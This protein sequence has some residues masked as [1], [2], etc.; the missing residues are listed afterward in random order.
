MI[1]SCG[2]DCAVEEESKVKYCETDEHKI[3]AMKWYQ[4]V[5]V[6]IP[7]KIDNP[8]PTLEEKKAYTAALVQC[9]KQDDGLT[10]AELQFIRG[11]QLCFG[12]GGE[13]I[14]A[15]P[16]LVKMSQEEVFQK[17]K[18][19]PNLKM[20]RRALIYHALEASASDGITQPEL[21]EIR[22]IAELLEME[23]QIV[24]QLY[25]TL[26]AELE[27]R[28]RKMKAIWGPEGNPWGTKYA[29]IKKLENG[30]L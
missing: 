22:K 2:S 16:E 23:P 6:G 5:S 10:A 27:Q 4:W 12:A 3:E 8:G 19:N 17:I 20:C 21:E 18:E 13:V 9:A 15:I 29:V 25:T 30:K 11:H 28:E 1:T 26:Q 7:P 14:D 24:D